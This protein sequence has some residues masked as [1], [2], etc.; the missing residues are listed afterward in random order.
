LRRLQYAPRQKKGQSQKPKNRTNNQNQK[1]NKTKSLKYTNCSEVQYASSALE[2]AAFLA[3][4]CDV[5]LKTTNCSE[6]HDAKFAHDISAK[7]CNKIDI[8]AFL[9]KCWEVEYENCVSYFSA[10]PKTGNPRKKSK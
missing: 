3:N 8:A 10:F 2:I 7:W 9:A 5:K 6:V 4:C 1:K